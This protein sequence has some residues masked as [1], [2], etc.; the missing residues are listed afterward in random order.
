LGAETRPER[1]RQYADLLARVH[2]RPG[3][4]TYWG[5]RPAPRSANPVA[6]ERTEA[7]AAAL[8]RALGDPDAAVRLAVL[9]RMLPAKGATRAASLR[10]LLRARPAP[11][12]MAAILEA[13]GDH[14]ADE[15][16]DLLTEVVADRSQAPAN[17]LTALALWPG[18]DEGVAQKK[19]AELAG[20]L[21]DG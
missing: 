7:I 4:W 3:P 11:D 17:R 6:W 5:Y 10:H 2:K 16:P 19:L 18:G 9:R 13:L 8:D 15:R 20:A 21:E 14:P 1:R 12:A